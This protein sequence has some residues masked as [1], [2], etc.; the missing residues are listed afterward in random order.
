MP[1]SAKE[2]VDSVSELISLPG[3]VMRVNDMTNDRQYSAADI[4]ETINQN[5]QLSARLL[6]IANSPF[7]S[8]P[9][10]INNIPRAITVIGT[11]ELRDLLL[12]TSAIDVF[13]ELPNKL[14]SMET[15]WRHSLRCGV[16]A[17]SLASHLHK[18]N[19][20]RFFAAGLLHDIGSLLI[21]H[22]LPKLADKVLFHSN[23]NRQRRFIIEEELIGFN[24]AT[25]GAELLRHWG[26]PDYIVEAV[27]HHHTPNLAKHHPQDA[28]IAHIANYLSNTMPSNLGENLA[29]SEA[30]DFTALKTAG[31]SPEDLQAILKH[32]ENQFNDTLEIM[33]Y[34]QV[35]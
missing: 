19:V 16:I 31:L 21:N 33:V 29:T 30:L 14:V 2:L 22:K 35:A 17:R 13:D 34:D 1:I 12:A 15:F 5:H 27:E 25:V 4:G 20:E 6:R 26:L 3:T 18:P 8:F 11:Q 7:F 28:A 23:K 24:H 9:S 10:H 32:S